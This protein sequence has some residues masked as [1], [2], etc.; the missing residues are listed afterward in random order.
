MFDG[1]ELRLVRPRREGVQLFAEHWR[2]IWILVTNA[3]PDRDPGPEYRVYA[4]ASAA[5]A[6]WLPW[7][8]SG[9][10]YSAVEQRVKVGVPTCI[11][12][13]AAVR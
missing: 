2:G 7:T 6:V 11:S 3:A 13:C 9:R 4:A 1:A 5:L 12:I 10:P 8:L